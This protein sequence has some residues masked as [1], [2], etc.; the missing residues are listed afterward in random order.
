MENRNGQQLVTLSLLDVP[1]HRQLS[2]VK[3]VSIRI[4]IYTMRNTSKFYFKKSFRLAFAIALRPNAVKAKVKSEWKREKVR[5]GKL[6]FSTT[7]S[8][9]D[10]AAHIGYSQL[11]AL[12]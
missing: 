5:Q 4:L 7:R 10:R 12:Q 9:L 6:H 11:P 8:R 2:T 1:L 3:Q